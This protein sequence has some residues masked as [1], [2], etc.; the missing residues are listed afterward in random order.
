MKDL[1]FKTIMLKG[2]AGGTIASIEKT[3]S[4][5]NVDTYTITLNDGETQTFEVTNGS[6]IASIEKTDTS[7]LLDTYTVTL[8]DGSTTQFVV[9]NGEDGAG[10]EVPAGSVLYFDSEDP[11]PEGYEQ[12]VDPNGARIQAAL[13]RTDG[14]LL[15]CGEFRNFTKAGKTVNGWTV[16]PQ[17]SY[18]ETTPAMFQPTNG[19][20]LPG[21]YQAEIWSPKFCSINT[22]TLDLNK[23]YSLTVTYKLSPTP[24]SEEHACKLENLTEGEVPIADEI[25]DEILRV[26]VNS[27]SA[28]GGSLRFYLYNQVITPIYITSV[29]LEQGR[30]ATDVVKIGKDYGV[31]SAIEQALSDRITYDM[32]F[33]NYTATFTSGVATLSKEDL[34]LSGKTIRFAMANPIYSSGSIGANG[35]AACQ[36]TDSGLNIYLRDAINNTVPANGSYNVAVFI[37]YS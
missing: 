5:L 34:G 30:V 19:L 6:S 37:A 8:T 9:Q 28:G 15:Y 29:R 25:F 2:E 7:G 21:N 27:F 35:I 17:Q 1:F 4:A 12:S 13:D 11:T 23:P 3:S 18:T 33:L 20:F 14:N 31:A 10:Y 36:I 22:N 26:R 32:S 24:D 16:A